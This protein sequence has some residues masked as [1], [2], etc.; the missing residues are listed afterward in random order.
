MIRKI[1]AAA[2]VAMAVVAGWWR[3]RHARTLAEL[4]SLQAARLARRMDKMGSDPANAAQRQM[5]TTLVSLAA[6]GLVVTD[7]RP[8][9]RTQLPDPDGTDGTDGTVTLLETRACIAGFADDDTK[10]WLDDLLY[11]AGKVPGATRYT[12]TS[13]YELYGPGTIEY[14]R[15]NGSD[16]GRCRGPAVERCDGRVTA[17]IGDQMNARQVY[18]AFPTRPAV[19]RE[20]RQAWQITICAPAEAWGEG[21]MFA[22]LHRLVLADQPGAPSPR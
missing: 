21:T 3:W 18:R 16:A 2:A 4:A 17:R 14:K 6:R 5:Y 19:Q 1:V 7:W 11:F 10:N 8:G 22:D 9:N 15:H 12:L 20:L 13:V